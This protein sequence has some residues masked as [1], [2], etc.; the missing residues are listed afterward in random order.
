MATIGIKFV[1]KRCHKHNMLFVWKLSKKRDS[2]CHI[3]VQLLVYFI[4]IS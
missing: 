2:V 1:K 4:T 3:T